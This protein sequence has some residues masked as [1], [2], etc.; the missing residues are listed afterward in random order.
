ML[1]SCSITK[2]ADGK[3]SLGHVEGEK[4]VTENPS[5]SALMENK[6]S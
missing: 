3:G 1:K 4:N 6:Q 5:F 2:Q